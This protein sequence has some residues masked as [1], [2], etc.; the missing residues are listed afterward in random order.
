MA[1][2]IGRLAVSGYAVQTK[3]LDALMRR[4]VLCF[5]ADASAPSSNAPKIKAECTWY[6]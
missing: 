2:A 1:A 4:V 5:E 6:L 3:Q